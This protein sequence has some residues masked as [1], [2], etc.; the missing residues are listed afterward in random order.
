MKL[1]SWSPAIATRLR[2]SPACV[3]PILLCAVLPPSPASASSGSGQV[4]TEELRGP[5]VPS[6]LRNKIRSVATTPI[7]DQEQQELTEATQAWI[8]EVRACSGRVNAVPHLAQQ[9]AALLALVTGNLHACAGR[10]RAVLDDLAAARLRPEGLRRSHAL[11]TAAVPL[12]FLDPWR[13]RN[14]GILRSMAH[15]NAVE[16]AILPYLQDST[17]HLEGYNPKFPLPAEDSRP[18][19]STLVEA[20]KTVTWHLWPQVRQKPL[21]E[22]IAV[23]RHERHKAATLTQTHELAVAAAERREANELA[24]DLAAEAKAA[25]DRARKTAENKKKKLRRAARQAEAERLEAEQLLTAQANAPT[26][27]QVAEQAALRE[28]ALR[29]SEA[30]FRQAEQVERTAELAHKQELRDLRA[31][32]ARE[33][34]DRTSQPRAASAPAVAEA[35]PRTWA[36]CWDPRADKERRRVHDPVEEFQIDAVIQELKEFG[37]DLLDSSSSRVLGGTDGLLFE[38]RPGGGRSP[39]RVIYARNPDSDSYTVLECSHHDQLDAAV[40]VAKERLGTLD[41]E[42]ALP[43]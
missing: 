26:A 19:A 37:P 24:E 43:F 22:A 31:R 14:L 40:E 7:T 42:A 13:D 17:F 9:T 34:A 18:V 30:R 23:A 20:L 4:T 15:F 8:Q 35:A 11:A 5:E 27:E 3:L 10:Y 39:W 32:L 28:Q 12:E 36:V 33:A 1:S 29:E 41:A 16:L 6:H 21:L 25:R 2:C 38:L